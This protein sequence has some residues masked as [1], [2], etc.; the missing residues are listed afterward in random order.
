MTMYTPDDIRNIQFT[1]SMGGYKTAEVDPF[2]DK[3]ADTVEALLREKAE[4]TKKLEVLA[5]KLVE[6][7]NDEDNIRINLR[8]W[9]E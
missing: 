3:C 8:S 2:I 4:L 5:D 7:R 1:K 6:Y 9:E